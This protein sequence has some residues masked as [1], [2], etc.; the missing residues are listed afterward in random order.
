VIM[1]FNRGAIATNVTL[2]GEAKPA[3]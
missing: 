3:K 1:T 2:V